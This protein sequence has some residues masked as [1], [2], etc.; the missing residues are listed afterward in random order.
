MSTNS[1]VERRREK[2]LPLAEPIVA[3]YGTSAVVVIDLSVGGALIEHYSRLDRDTERPLRLQ[4]GSDDFG[5]RA[6][7]IRCSVDRILPGDD[8]LTIYRSGLRF[9]ESDAEQVARL[10]ELIH[11]VV[12]ATLA[13]QRANARGDQPDTSREMP[14]FRD[15]ILTTADPGLDE[16][17]GKLLPGSAIV[18]E[19]GYLR[20]TLNGNRFKRTWT[21]DPTQPPDGFTVSA[22]EPQADIELLCRAYLESGSEGRQ[23]IRNLAQASLEK[24]LKRG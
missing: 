4:W 6:R 21:L 18:R 19:R 15:G 12:A 23:L 14:V 20:M 2:R 7:V 5:I 16:K 3:R 10:K 1:A 17:M 11:G 24:K 9:E 13:E 8:G 22:G